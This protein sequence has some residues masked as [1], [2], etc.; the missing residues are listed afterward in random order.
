MLSF[1][2]EEATEAVDGGAVG[3]GRSAVARGE[4][5]QG[6]ARSSS[7]AEAKLFGGHTLDIANRSG[8]AFSARR[9]SF[10]T[11]LLAAAEAMG[12]RRSLAQGLAHIAGHVG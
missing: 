7:S 1:C 3:G 10:A 6:W 8:M 9:V 5:T 11:D 4:A 2:Y 12:G